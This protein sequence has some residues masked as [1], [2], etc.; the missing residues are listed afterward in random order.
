MQKLSHE[1][2]VEGARQDVMDVARALGVMST[3]L[4]KRNGKKIFRATCYTNECHNLLLWIL[5]LFDELPSGNDPAS[6]ALFC[7]DLTRLLEH[8]ES[9]GPGSHL[10]A[11]ALTQRS[12]FERFIE[13]YSDIT[14]VR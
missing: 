4:L 8:L 12:V 5:G 9:G 1:R 11:Y 7:D 13:K 6:L 3:R 14:P 10:Y 2:D